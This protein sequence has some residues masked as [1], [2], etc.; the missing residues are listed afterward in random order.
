MRR[1]LCSSKGAGGAIIY[2]E[3]NK[4][5]SKKNTSNCLVFGPIS[6]KGYTTQGVWWEEVQGNT[7]ASG[8]TDSSWLSRTEIKEILSDWKGLE[9]FAKKKIDEYKSKNCTY[10][11]SSNLSSYSMTCSS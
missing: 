5:C 7:G 4:Y 3:G 1:T 6:D 10:Q 11:T 8:L 2:K 9:D